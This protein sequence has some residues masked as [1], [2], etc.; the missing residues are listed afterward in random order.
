MTSRVFTLFCGHNRTHRDFEGKSNGNETNGYIVI[1]VSM[2]FYSSPACLGMRPTREEAPATGMGVT[3]DR[4]PSFP[5]GGR[6]GRGARAVGE[7]I[8]QAWSLEAC[9]SSFSSAGTSGWT[10]G[11]V[12]QPRSQGPL[13]VPVWPPGGL[14]S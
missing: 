8:G 9:G 3:S 11:T 13:P 6:V 12:M 1:Y 2:C 4:W 5:L 10:L 7:E 14:W